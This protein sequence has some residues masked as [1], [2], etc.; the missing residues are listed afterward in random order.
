MTVDPPRQRDLPEELS[1]PRM[2]LRPPRI[3]D[4]TIVNEAVRETFPALNQW[5]PWARHMPSIA[6]TETVMR[7]AAAR[8]RTKDELT[9]LMFRK[10]RGTLVG[11][12]SLHHIDW[13][14]PKFELGYWIRAGE[15]GHGLMTEAVIALTDFAF[16]YWDAERLE[17]RCDSRNT[18]SAAVAVRAHY[19]LEATLRRDGRDNQGQLRDTQIYVQLNA[20]TP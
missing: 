15:S 12:I 8:W 17:I 13:D 14:V 11:L 9:L 19:T 2:I 20:H 10:G 18:R 3:G 7:E 1:T 4:G 6:E 5:M 16:A